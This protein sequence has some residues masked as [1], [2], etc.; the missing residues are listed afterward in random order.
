LL[1]H[2]KFGLINQRPA[3]KVIYIDLMKTSTLQDLYQQ[4]A[5]SLYQSRS[6]GILAKLTDIEI[7]SRLR[8]TVSVNPVTQFPEISFD[9]KESQVTQ[10]LTSLMNWLAEEKKMILIFDEFQQILTYP[11]TNA[12]GFL[13]S[14]MMRHSHVRFIFSGSDQHLLEDLFQNP[15]RPFFNST[16]FM[17][18]DP[19]QA[20]I[21]K[22]F[23]KDHYKQAR[24]SISDDALNYILHISDGETYAIQKLCNAVFETGM[25]EITLP[26]AK[27]IF[28]NVLL[29]QQG[30]YER[31]R[32][33]IKADS[34][35]FK[36]LRAIA[37]NKV[38]TEPTGK[39]FM[40]AHGLSNSS[41]VLKSIKSLDGYHLIS[42]VIVD[43]TLGYYVNDALFKAWLNTL[44]S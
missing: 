16:Q 9:L 38:V 42:K 33:L 20:D 12:E 37:R 8:M 28:V 17:G 36:V 44:P 10:S 1:E 5:Q 40:T 39:E 41:S 21:Y 27:E 24:R 7:L 32:T 31:I 29:E 6:K 19:I 13:R 3:W 26:I 18:L 15:S 43:D 34:I 22:K 30:Y 2:L 14:E 11:Q 35:Q 4:L 23:I 25:Q